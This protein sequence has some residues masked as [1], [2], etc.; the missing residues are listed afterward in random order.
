M[1]VGKHHARAAEKTHSLLVE[2]ASRGKYSSS[3]VQR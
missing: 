1:E 3:C 2:E